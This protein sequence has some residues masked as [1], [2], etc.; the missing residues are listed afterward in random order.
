MVEPLG[1]VLERVR[2]DL[3]DADRLVRA[4]A[5]GRR[6][7]ERPTHRR[8]ELR[9]V[10]LRQGRLLQVV[11]FDDRQAFTSNVAGAE[12]ETAVAQLID[13]PFGNWHVETVDGTVQVRVTKKGDAQVHTSPAG[14]DPVEA[15]RTHDRLKSRLLDPSDPFLRAVGISDG[16]GGIRPG[17]RDKYRQVEEFLRALEPLLEH[18]R[19]A[20]GDGSL[21][22][23]DLGCGNAY[24][25]FA[26]YRWL[27][28]RHGLDVALVGVDV[29]AQARQRNTELAH[30]LG[31]DDGIR[32]VEGTIEDFEPSDLPHVVLALHACDTASDDALA[33]AVRWRAP[34][35][36]V[37]PC[38]HHDV[39]RQLLG[40]P[41]PQP[42]GPLARHGI[43]RERFADVLTDA[44]RASVLRILGYR[45]EVV[46]FVESAHTPR[47]TLLRAVR[48]GAPPDPVQVT[49]YMELIADWG[50]RP[51]LHARLS[52]EVDAATASGPRRVSG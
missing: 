33:R 36:L 23:V 4:V 2:A 5:A 40:S 38:C 16:Q 14:P 28:D 8:A 26:A 7:G 51:A 19:A 35:V 20:V 15:D 42:Y 1:P 10:D 48:T 44:V 39:Q 12:A 25:T 21:R 43:L 34:V 37:A 9:W 52:D 45:V 46:E 49:E 41:P 18:A 11:T 24:L 17:R 50:I 27:T 13:E 47:N 30:S 31:W 6:T 32:F 3:L 29:K 22:I